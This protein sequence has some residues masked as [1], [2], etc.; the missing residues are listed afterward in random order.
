MKKNAIFFLFFIFTIIF[1]GAQSRLG[2]EDGSLNEEPL[3]HATSI[4]S[5]RNINLG[6]TLDQVKKIIGEDPYFNYSGDDDVYILPA[7]QQTLIECSGNS[8]IKR[9]YFQFFENKLYILIIELK[10]DKIDFYTMFTTLYKKYG[11]YIIFSPHDV[12]WE[13]NNTRLALERPVIV[14]YIDLDVFNKLIEMGI[15]KSNSQNL[16]LKQFLDQF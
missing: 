15:I 14:K 12:V 10:E 9:A 3:N 2:T 1:T 5:F 11:N 6:M 8:Y 7:K 13:L 4:N 16:N